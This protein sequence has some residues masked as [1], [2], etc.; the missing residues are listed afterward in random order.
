MEAG[1]W[2]NSFVGDGQA[3]NRKC[4]THT[5]ATKRKFETRSQLACHGVVAFVHMG[6]LSQGKE[7]TRCAIT[8]A[9]VCMVCD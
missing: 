3:V 9:Q 7:E 4:T 2:V 1:G 6:P 8:Y 5:H